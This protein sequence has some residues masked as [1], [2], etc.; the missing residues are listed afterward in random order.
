[1][2]CPI[3]NELP[4]PPKG[5]VGW[6]WTEAS[7]PLSASGPEDSAWPRISIITPSFN[8][9]E[10]IEETIRSVL[11]Q[12]YP[13]LEYFIIDG[14]STDQT[15]DVLQK[16]KPWLGRWV[17][18]PDNGQS[19]AINKGLRQVSGSIWGWI[20]SD[21]LFMPGSLSAVADAHRQHPRAL[22]AG[23]V[24]NFWTGSSKKELI[25]QSEIELQKFVEFWNREGHWHQPG[26]FFPT[27]LRDEVGLLD[28]SLCYLFDYDLLCRALTIS[29]VHYL[30]QTVASFRLHNDSKTVSQGD[31]FLFELCRITQRYWHHLPEVDRAGYERHAAGLLFC[32]GCQRLIYG[33]PQAMRFIAEGLKTHPGWAVTSALKLLPAWLRKKWRS[34]V[35]S[36]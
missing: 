23:D 21:D 36:Q 14:G 3:L 6:P 22:I 8:Q 26:I 24:L 4:A 2:N 35:A 16:Y 11:L 25:R 32:T 7:R 5:K 20:N 33:R 15:L 28:E 9:G 12:G 30:R 17:S 27:Y 18:E 10:F 29:T 31:L 34:T 1:M 13:D 19:H